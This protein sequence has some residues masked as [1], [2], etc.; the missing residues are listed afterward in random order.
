MTVERDPDRLDRQMAVP[1]ADPDG[2]VQPPSLYGAIAGRIAVG[3]YVLQIGEQSGGVVREASR[4]ERAHIRPRPT[5]ILL[6]PRLI[7][8]LLDRRMELAAA[9]SA[10]DAGLPIEVSGEPGVGKTAILRQL[11]HHP[12]AASFVDGIVYL[13]ARHLSSDDLLQLI[14]EAFYESDEICK[15]TAAEVR[16]GLQDKQALILLD[17]VQL[18]QHELEQVI[19][20]AP[21][22][23]FAVAT[24]ERCLW[25]EVRSIPLK[26]LPVD[27]AVLLLERE[28]ERA[29]DASEPSA[30]RSLCAS[31]EGHPLRIQQ[32]AA[33]IREQGISLDECARNI[34][35]AGLVTE[36]MAWID[37]KERR[38]LLALT[39]V[40]G[41]PL[42]VQHVSSIA[43]VPDVEPLLMTLVRRGLV[44][45]SQSRHQ[46][47]EGVADQLRRS[48]D[49]N[50][51]MNRGITYFT[52]WAERYRR[53]PGDLL[54]ESEALLRVQ[55]AATDIRRWGEVLR[56]GRLLEGALVIGAR[57]GAWTIALERCLAAAKAIGDRSSEA[58]ALHEIG[59]LAV[60]LGE[61]GM[62]RASLSQAVKLR[63]AMRE[64]GAAQA[65]RRSLSLVI[66]PVSEASRERA[67]APSEDVPDLDAMPLRDEALPTMR[68]RK[69]KNVSAVFLAA[70]LLAVFGGM[71]YWA[72]PARL[73][74][75]SWNA[76]SIRSFLQSGLG[77]TTPT[78]AT[79]AQS[80][81]PAEL[82]VLQFS[83]APDRI[84][85]GES[86]RLCYE[87]ANGGGI[88]IDPDIG[89]VAALRQNCVS[90][91]PT[92]TTIYTL[93]A[94]D[95]N[96]E[97]VR[98]SLRVL[99]S[100]AS[101]R[102]SPL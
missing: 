22:S 7:R 33:L 48:A 16:R 101:P 66:A 55:Q 78:T 50:P 57:W 72:R 56:L 82:R 52:A 59:T 19:D 63:E 86:V 29:P 76:A 39:A 14:F 89:E 43:D 11:A 45:S 1:A 64:D 6:R 69:T 70:F 3:R 17:D 18:A 65:S 79:T 20:I 85:R 102:A 83:A 49:L 96:A 47:A 12:R 67:T 81:Q 51:W 100:P 44:V 42:Q 68:V 27:D 23:L 31:L 54:D 10:L 38:A 13:A 99:V 24:R 58:W 93:T 90:A 84:A 75:T 61:P 4:A 5:P 15:P 25:G 60:C 32:A 34:V 97:S 46:L 26:G 87:V 71:A 80:P 74:W 77:G 73:S 8:G 35:P 41:V 91:T 28:I 36:L 95:A 88:R 94:R 92:E 98:Q 2:H 9:L 21:H 30:A 53:S 40:P 37:A 62:A